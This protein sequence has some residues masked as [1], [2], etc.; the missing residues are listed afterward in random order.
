MT[1]TDFT[2]KVTETMKIRSTNYRLTTNDIDYL[3]RNVFNEITQDIALDFIHQQV[4]IDQETLVYDV[5]ALY[6]PTANE[7]AMEVVSIV[8]DEGRD[9]S[10]LFRETDY[11]VF[12]I[13]TLSNEYISKQILREYDG[14]YIT[15]NRRVIL[16]IEQLDYKQQLL[17]FP[18]LVE[19]MMMYTHDA[20]PNPTASGFPQKET[21]QHYEM[22]YNAI[23]ILK[24]QLPQRM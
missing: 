12:T 7:I 6:T 2:T 19:G 14:R 22:Y 17:V 24:N 11:N 15:F 20:I 18:A 9:I 5:Q 13:D 10:Q 1:F 8:D 3:M 23:K 16:D 21:A 4:L